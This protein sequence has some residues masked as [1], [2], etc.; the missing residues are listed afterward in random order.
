MP[1][2]HIYIISLLKHQ[3]KELK[4]MTGGIEINGQMIH[5]IWF[6]YD[7]ELLANSQNDMK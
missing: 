4:S 7:I 1:V 6:A 5:S 2:H 3:L